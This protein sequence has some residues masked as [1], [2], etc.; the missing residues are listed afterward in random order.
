[1]TACPPACETPMSAVTDI[2]ILAGFFA[3]LVVRLRL[4]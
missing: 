1:M 3:F 4:Q 2:V